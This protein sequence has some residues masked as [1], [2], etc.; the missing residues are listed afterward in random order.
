MRT[1]TS[2]GVTTT[3]TYEHGRLDTTTLPNG[4]LEDRGYDKAG[5]LETLVN[6]KNAVVLSKAR[7][8]Y[9]PNGNPTLVT[10]E[11]ETVRY[12]YNTRNMLT[13]ACYNADT[14]DTDGPTTSA[15]YKYGYDGVGNRITKERPVNGANEVTTYTYNADD[16][17]LVKDGP[18]GRCDFTWDAN[19]NMLGQ[20]GE[21]WAYNDADQI[22]SVTENGATMRYTYDGDGKRLTAADGTSAA[23]ITQYQWDINN[24]L[25][26]LARESNGDGVLRRSYI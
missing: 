12:T 17:L 23:Q 14:C 15:Y 10:T 9:D 22:T 24:Q 19:G 1:V 3:Y 20:C 18:S 13:L 4:Y 8:A 16:E 26:Q 21:T 2:G 6:S 11:D 5:R 25:P 7:Y